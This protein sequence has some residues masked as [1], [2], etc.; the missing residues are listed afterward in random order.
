MLWSTICGAIRRPGPGLRAM[1]NASP[2]LAWWRWN[3][4]KAVELWPTSGAWNASFKDSV[5]TWH[6]SKTAVLG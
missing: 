3:Y 2:S 1:L 5:S 4:C 6:V